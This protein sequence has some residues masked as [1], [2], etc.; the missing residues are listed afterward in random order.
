MEES[1]GSGE[2]YAGKQRHVVA[3]LQEA[4]VIFNRGVGG[5]GFGEGRI[6]AD[7]REKVGLKRALAI[8]KG[9]EERELIGRDGGAV[10][11]GGE[12]VVGVP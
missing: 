8:E 2:V 12:Q 10:G 11:A 6:R 5:V 4:E 3:G 9:V 7:G 1:C